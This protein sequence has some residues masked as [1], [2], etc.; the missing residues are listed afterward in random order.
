M[1]TMIKQMG[2]NI[3]QLMH[4]NKGYKGIQLRYGIP[5][6]HLYHQR[7]YKNQ[8]DWE[9]NLRIWNDTKKYRYT[10]TIYGIKEL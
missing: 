3:K 8:Q 7:P 1:E 4:L 9:Y 2:Q 6:L 5:L 10:K